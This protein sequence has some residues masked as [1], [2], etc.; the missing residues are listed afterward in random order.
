MMRL[1]GPSVAI[2]PLTVRVA[3]LLI[4][5]FVIE[6]AV[7]AAIVPSPVS[8]LLVIEPPVIASVPETDVQ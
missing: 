4:V 1:S 5:R 6:T 3:P 8:S 7:F 2:A